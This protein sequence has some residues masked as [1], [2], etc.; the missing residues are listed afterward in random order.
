MAKK[1]RKKKQ[2]PAPVE[3]RRTEAM[4]VAWMLS[5]TVTF[6]ALFFAGVALLTLPYMVA[7]AGEAGALSAIPHLL[8]AVATV[9]GTVS[10]LLMGCAIRYRRTPPPPMIIVISAMI[11]FCPFA[12]HLLLV[13]TL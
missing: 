12:I 6:G 9:T 1:K 4:T 8:L 5:T 3:D 11:C 13:A 10:I 7:R 2:P